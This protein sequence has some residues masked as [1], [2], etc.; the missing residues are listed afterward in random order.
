[1]W[2][3]PGCTSRRRRG[4]LSPEEVRSLRKLK[5][6]R[7]RLVA[8]GARTAGEALGGVSE[9]RQARASGSSADTA[10]ADIEPRRTGIS[11]GDVSSLTSGLVATFREA[12]EK[13]QGR[14]VRPPG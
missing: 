13:V 3:L 9:T 8:R 11:R 2:S 10:G 12:S 6:E 7:L 14:V 5:P 1:M 4:A